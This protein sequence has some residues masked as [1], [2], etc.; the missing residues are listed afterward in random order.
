SEKLFSLQ[1]LTEEETEAFDFYVSCGVFG[2]FTISVGQ[3]IQR[4]GGGLK[5]KLKY[6]KDRLILPER[7]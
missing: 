3:N 2:T 1:P 5:G 4:N 6:I 7:D